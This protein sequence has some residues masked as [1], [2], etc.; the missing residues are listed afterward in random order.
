ML[1]NN[2]VT[3]DEEEGI[4]ELEDE[5][6]NVTRFE[7]IDRIEM[8]GEIYFALVPAEYDEEEGAAEFVVL[9]QTVIDGED[10]L[11][12]VDNDDEYNEVGEYFLKRFSE[13]AE[14]D[15]DSEE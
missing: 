10:M 1:E 2:D 13:L 9:K 11:V 7:F 15:L 4:I 12:T 5:E 14:L 6:G 8:N 3:L